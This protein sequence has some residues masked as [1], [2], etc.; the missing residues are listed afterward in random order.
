MRMRLAVHGAAA[1]LLAG[2]M[3]GHRLPAQETKI[4]S[5]LTTAA[6]VRQLK[7]EEADRRYRVR[8]RGVLTFVND[9]QVPAR[10]M[11]FIQDETG[12]IFFTLNP[13][14]EDPPLAVGQL[15]EVEGYSGRGQYAPV[16]IGERLRLLGQAPLPP[17]KPVSLE[18]LLSG[19][20]DSQLVEIQ[21][22]ARSVEEYST[23]YFW[24]EIATGGGRLTAEASELPVPHPEAL[25][26][27]AIKV[28]GICI[29]H[30]NLGRQL[31]DV[32]L[33]IPRAEDLVV[34]AAAP[35]R[36]PFSLPTQSIGSLLQ[37]SPAGPIGHRV[38][39]SGRVIYHQ[40]HDALYIQDEIEGLYVETTQDG[41]LVPGDVVEVLGF[42]ATG[43]YTPMLQDAAFRKIAPGSQPRPD[44]I[45]V[46]EALRGPHHCRLVRIEANVLDRA[47]QRHDE[48]LVLQA[49]GFVFHAYL[50]RPPEG[51]DLSH[52]PN[53]SRV[54]VTGVC[55][56][57]RGR[58]WQAGEEWRAKSFRILLRSAG[59]VEVLKQPSW[60]TSQK[61]LWALALLGVAVL[62]T[63]AWVAVL[64]RRVQKQTLVIRQQLQTEV[65]LKERYQDLF[66]NAN[67]VVFTHDLAGRLTSIN[68][69]GERLLQ[70]SRAEILSKNLLDFVIDEQRPAARR[71]LAQLSQA[72]EASAGEWDFVNASGQ[73]LRLEINTRLIDQDGRQGEAE[74]VARD[75]TERKRLEREI[76]EISN[77][78]QQRIGHDLHDGVC[79]QLA[80]IAYRSHVLAS[81]L[82]KKAV[83]EADE[84]ETLGDLISE[85]LVQTRGVAR[86]L[87]PV[88][89][90]ENGLASALEELAA[91]TA[92]VY[93][94]NCRFTSLN[95]VP[96]LENGVA[97]H[98]YYIAQEAALNAARHSRG[99]NVV[100][101]L[102]NDPDRMSLKIR[103]DGG[104]FQPATGGHPGMG[105]NIMRYRA[106]VIGATLDLTSLPGAGTE[107]TCTLQPLAKA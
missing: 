88:R 94:V 56:I 107:I 98:L 36:D 51:V 55:L 60:W 2:L 37:F 14:P 3:V 21:G 83:S 105:I 24:I 32:R 31:I 46:D 58:E 62:L 71:W 35:R 5:E 81:R 103:D 101:T 91:D 76:L 57:D 59:D 70:R 104:G 7:P 53:G 80:A 16:V 82:Q 10:A 19:Q 43:E 86:G 84:V 69:A 45:N 48:F 66:E 95:P 34:T 9:Q 15:V 78:E 89:L 50:T 67:D 26:D 106:R 6:Q 64:R 11:R 85:T 38:K 72:G 27:S 33:L 52:I 99:T 18:Q 42:P 68:K 41:Q 102:E 22:I 1:V 92:S 77:K 30:F 79:Q 100:I 49:D 40:N 23:N 93:H 44:F 28:R 90:E 25:A 20:E 39:V 8:L 75:V 4:S 74:G 87:F 17:A 29:T 54:A 47:R 73:R 97:L 13:T 61:L 63:L 96:P 12:G 65:T